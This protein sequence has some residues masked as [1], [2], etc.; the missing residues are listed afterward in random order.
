MILDFRETNSQTDLRAD[1]CVVGAGAAGITLAREFAR[2]NAKVIVLES[3]GEEFEGET[4][5]LYAGENVGLPY[6]LE[7][8]RLRFLGGTTN[9]WEGVCGPLEEID[10]QVRSWVPYSGWPLSR[11]EL[12]PFYKRAQS[13]CRLGPYLY[14]EDV[15]AHIGRDAIGFDPSKIQY[16]FKQL[17][18]FPVRFGEEYAGDLKAAIKYSIIPPCKCYKYSIE[19]RS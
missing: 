5:D 15:W 2:S 6:A 11:D 7:A 16:V 17:R 1:L 13:I 19:F 8:S 4:Q 10:F 9:H 18:E 3:G 12:V 14:G